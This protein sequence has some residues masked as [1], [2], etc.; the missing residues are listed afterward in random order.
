[1]TARVWVNRM[2][3]A[4]WGE[5]L[6]RTPSNF[7]SLGEEPTHP[8]LL[9]F[10]AHEF[11]RD[12]W[13]TKRLH[14]SLVLT[15]AYQRSSRPD[16][17]AQALDPDNRLLW[18]HNLRRL[19]AEAIRDAVLAVSGRLDRSGHRSLSGLESNDGYHRQKDNEFEKPSR[20]IYLP[21]VR[22]QSNEWMALFDGADPSM[23]HE[24]RMATTVPGQA[25]ALMNDPMILRAARDLAAMAREEAG[26]GFAE[27]ALER[28]HLRVYGRL[29]RAGER[30][31]LHGI[32]DASDA[33][34]AWERLSRILLASNEFI[35]IH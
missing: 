12:G 28:L 19:E 34:G 15:R 1:M 2:W 29:P 27:Q 18:R 7:G 21:V 31:L 22:S 35:H 13:S 32:L 11:I 23:H 30:E 10:L 25:L 6:V 14:R 4:L 17:E 26:A 3:L 24:R 16:A 33:E 9:D 8:D 20:S 5:G